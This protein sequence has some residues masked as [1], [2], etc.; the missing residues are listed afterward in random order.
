MY[1]KKHINI[2][3]GVFILLLLLLFIIILTSV[4][5]SNVINENIKYTIGIAL[6]LFF[7]PT[8]KSVYET[9][10]N[11]HFNFSDDIP[12]EILNKKKHIKI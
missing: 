12:N 9:L 7:G 4:T 3:N 1:K 8:M 6:S 5:Q 10:F 2:I 11:L